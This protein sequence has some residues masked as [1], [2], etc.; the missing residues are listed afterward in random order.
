MRKTY[1]DAD[2]S[3]NTQSSPGLKAKPQ[4]PEEL[5]QTIRRGDREAVE[6]LPA[7]TR[8]RKGKGNTIG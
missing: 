8:C 7:P 3:R 1:R 6:N 5:E 2:F 4:M